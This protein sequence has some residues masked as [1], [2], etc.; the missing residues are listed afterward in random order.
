MSA[1][2]AARRAMIHAYTAHE[3]I[4]DAPRHIYRPTISPAVHSSRLICRPIS[5]MRRWLA[6]NE[7]ILRKCQLVGT[8]DTD[9]RWLRKAL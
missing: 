2:H 8:S 1:K 3:P 5:A 7:P 9:Q 6:G 4:T